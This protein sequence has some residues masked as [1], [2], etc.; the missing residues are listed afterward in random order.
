MTRG[1][2]FWIVTRYGY[3]RHTSLET[4]LAEKERLR[5]LYPQHK[6]RVIRCKGVSSSSASRREAEILGAL[7][8]CRLH[9]DNS[10]ETL[11]ACQETGGFGDE[12]MD[13]GVAIDLAEFDSLIARIDSAIALACEVPAL[14]EDIAEAAGQGVA[15]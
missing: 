8:A 15:A 10:A 9:L 11:R 1:D 3:R 7:R 12:T 13:R 14:P 6:F 4:A 2:N 5:G